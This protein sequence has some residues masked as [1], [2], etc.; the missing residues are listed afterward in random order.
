MRGLVLPPV[1]VVVVLDDAKRSDSR[2]RGMEAVDIP[3][4]GARLP[5]ALGDPTL[6]E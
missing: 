4:D 3:G 2:L 1:G 6:K 5:L